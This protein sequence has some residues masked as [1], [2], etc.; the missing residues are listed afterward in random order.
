MITSKTV[1]FTL[2]FDDLPWNKNPIIVK[3]QYF[4]LGVKI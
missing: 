3:E 2:K 4:V 1:T